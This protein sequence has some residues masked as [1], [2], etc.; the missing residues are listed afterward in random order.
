MSKKG[1]FKKKKFRAL[2]QCFGVPDISNITSH[3]VIFNYS[4]RVLTEYETSVLSRGLRFCL[5]PK[6]VDKYDTKCSF[7]LLYRDFRNLHLNLDAE[8]NDRLRTKLKDICYNYTQDYKFS[9]HREIL[10]PSE[11]TALRNLQRDTSIVITRPDKGNGVVLLSKTRYLEK[12]KEIL[13]DST[14]FKELTDNPTKTRERSLT[15]YLLKLKHAGILN[16]NEYKEIKP[17][18]SNPGIMY[19]LPKVHKDNYPIRPIV[20]S[21][22]TYNYRLAKYLVQILKPLSTNHNSIKDSFTFSDWIRQQQRQGNSILCSYDVKS[23]FTNIPL[24]E[25]I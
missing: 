11:W 3:N 24:E 7:E 14:K 16:E 19:G 1:I 8:S 15:N 17:V 10:S 22:G 25:T 6:K 20:S 9:N 2:K 21:I 18:G 5:P 13:S 4:H 12:V 23:L